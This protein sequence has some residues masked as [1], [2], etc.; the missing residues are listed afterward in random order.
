MINH[1]QR[2][3]IV[4]LLNPPQIVHFISPHIDMTLDN[5]NAS[6]L[7]FF[8]GGGGWTVL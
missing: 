4:H 5:V 1:F 7:G 6:F 3:N 2:E 8:V